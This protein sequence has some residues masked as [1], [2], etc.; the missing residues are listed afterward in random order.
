MCSVRGN[1]A[2]AQTCALRELNLIA[3]LVQ[4][5]LKKGQVGRPSETRPFFA[6]PKERVKTYSNGLCPCSLG[7]KPDNRALV[8]DRLK[9]GRVRKAIGDVD[10]SSLL[11]ENETRNLAMGA[12][13]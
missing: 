2:I 12:Y 3:A 6:R 11:P 13:A 1:A 8:Q 10:P 5:R 4:D 9:K 7:I